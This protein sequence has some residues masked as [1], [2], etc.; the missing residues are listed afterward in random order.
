MISSSYIL[1]IDQGTS[2]TK[3]IIFDDMGTICAEATVPLKTHYLA[4]GYVEQDPED[5]YKNVLQAVQSCVDQYSAAGGMLS[6]I[7][8]CGISN[9]RETFVLWDKE[10]LPLYNAV[11]WQCKR[12][13][14]ICTALQ[15]AGLAYTIQEKTGLCIDPYFSGTKLM[16]LYQHRAEIRKTIDAGEAYFGTIDTWLLYRLTGGEKYLTDYTNA[17][18]TLFF[19]LDTLD[20]DRE[21]LSHFNLDGIQLPEV[22]PSSYAFGASYFEG[23]FEEALPIHA[24]IGDSHAAAFGEA[25]IY[26]GTAKAT[27]G[28]GCSILFNVGS[29]RKNSTSGM[30]ST[31]C[32]ST[33][34]RV[35]Y[36]LEGIIVSC[37]SPLAWL[38]TELGLLTDFSEA[39][40]MANSVED[41]GGVYLIPA[42][43]GLGAPYWD[44]NRKASIEGLTFANNKNH[45]VRAALES[46]AYQIKDVL[47]AMNRDTGIAVK[48]LMVNGGASSNHFVTQFLSDLL[49]ASVIKNENKNISAMGAGV[50]AGLK[51]GIFANVDTIHSLFQRHP[52]AQSA[53]VQKVVEAYKGWQRVM[54]RGVNDEV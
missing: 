10:G 38:K 51:A 21:L 35:D 20:W 22:K 32:W 53:S 34:E 44:M 49:D 19:N 43:S 46:I 16:W 2:G 52:I 37:A 3:S 26:P 5:I 31:I 23:L 39:E 11:V 50:L 24:L 47:Q 54:K 17:S 6:A 41:N 36:A 33:E 7:K 13:V 27:L 15:A 30:V 18:R 29:E 42:F 40:A 8:S 1:A 12:S 4:E 28:T 48:E 45:I 9:Q 25:C 14:G